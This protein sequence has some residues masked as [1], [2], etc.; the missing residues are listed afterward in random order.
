MA[1]KA[2]RWISDEPSV[3]VDRIC[4]QCL[5]YSSHFPNEFLSRISN[6]HF[7]IS[8]FMLYTTSRQCPLANRLGKIFTS[9]PY[10]V[11]LE[12]YVPPHNSYLWYAK[13]RNRRVRRLCRLRSRKKFASARI[14]GTVCGR[15]K[16]R[17][18]GS[19]STQLDSRA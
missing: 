9:R 15:D 7:I 12:Y 3:G 6:S 2:M 4:S 18:E 10:L 19:Q 13:Y 17:Y 5:D 8:S 14:K 16:S 1:M 11:A